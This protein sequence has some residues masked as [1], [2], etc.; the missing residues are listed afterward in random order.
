[1]THHITADMADQ[2]ETLRDFLRDNRGR[3]YSARSVSRIDGELQFVAEI[4]VP[5][6][7]VRSV[8][9]WRVFWQMIRA[10]YRLW[11]GFY[12]GSAV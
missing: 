12:Q 9:G 1:V 5:V 4:H 8:S 7:L 11:V 3:V 10:T 6:S 2:V